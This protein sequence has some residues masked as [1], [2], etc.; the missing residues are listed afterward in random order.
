[1][2]KLHKSSNE[3]E[4]K[5]Y[6]L[7]IVGGGPSTI[8]FI[9]YL[10]QNKLA[11]KVFS[12][13]SILI[14]EKNANIG[15][16]CLGNYGINTNT[17]SEGFPRLICLGEENKNSKL[18]LSPSKN[19]MKTSK[20]YN[21]SEVVIK[22]NQKAE[23]RKLYNIPATSQKEKL[24]FKP[25][26]LFQE[27]YT[28]SCVQTLLS[29]GNRPAPLP[30]VGYF[31]DCLGNF[32]I[33]HINKKYSRNIL[34]NK[35]EVC[36]IKIYN[37]EEF[38]L[39]VNEDKKQTIIKCKN[40]IMATGGKQN[41]N[42]SYLG[43]IKS[44]IGDHNVFLSEEVLQEATY[45]K[46]MRSLGN[47]KKE[48]KRVVIIGGSHSGFSCAWILLNAPSKYKNIIQGNEFKNKQCNNCIIECICF[49]AIKDKNW[50]E[51]E[52]KED[53]EV[54]ILYKDLIR[55]YYTNEEEAKED[56]Y[57]IY[58]RPEALNKQGKVYPFIGIRGDAKM[59]YK[60]IMDGEEKRVKL[61]K[62][63]NSS[64]QMPIIQQADLVIWACGYTTNSIP[65][66][67]NRNQNIEFFTDDVGTIEVDKEL[68]LMTKLKTTIPN[69]YGIGQ[70]YS[71]KAPEIING[72]KARADSIH[73]YNTHTSKKLYKSLE[74]FINKLSFNGKMNTTITYS[75]SETAK[76]LLLNNLKNNQQKEVLRKIDHTENIQIE[77]A[78]NPYAKKFKKE[79]T[80]NIITN[81]LVLVN[82]GSS[83]LSNPLIKKENFLK[84][85][86]QINL[87]HYKSENLKNENKVFQKNPFLN[88]NQIPNGDK[89]SSFLD[90]KEYGNILRSNSIL[91]KK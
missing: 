90:R 83:I 64:Q 42:N 2:D 59:L 10:F 66:V 65:F 71:T 13:T 85:N 54:F 91:N 67:D 6:D 52:L 17:S 88:A 12:S 37:N 51:L 73:L 3:T 16:G 41:K 33:D 56:N 45:L 46:M 50:G 40:L 35:S 11:D 1:M 61:I 30:L 76:P 53:V 39:S 77:I 55:V 43:E 27:L 58:N 8:S 14:I 26:P 62:T 38:G 25:I 72:K 82:N 60:K 32:I 70:G 89:K 80:K 86:Q 29:I 36:K 47:I 48:K 4:I 87:N 5:K 79:N 20:N 81:K 74:L 84:L 23:R 7:V 22:T 49:G 75:R 31:L 34:L 78:E 44:L 19:P 18:S 63:D 28:S 24:I 15:S 68:H 9:C 57:T 69:L 21:N